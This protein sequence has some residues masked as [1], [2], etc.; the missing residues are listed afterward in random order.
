[1]I[2]NIAHNSKKVQVSAEISND[3]LPTSSSVRVN[4]A[5]VTKILHVKRCPG[6]SYMTIYAAS[7]NQVDFII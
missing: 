7:S 3:P 2:I 6:N 4:V 5:A 1:M